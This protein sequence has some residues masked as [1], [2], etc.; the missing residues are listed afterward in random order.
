MRPEPPEAD[1]P[2]PALLREL[3]DELTTLVR[4][5]LALARAE[6]TASAKPVAASAGMLGTGALFGLGAFGAGTA[7][8]IALIGIWLPVW[9]AAL[10]VTAIYGCVAFVA[11]LTAK[12]TLHDAAP[13]GL[14]RTAQTLK[15]DIEWAKTRAKSSA[16]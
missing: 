8:L 14:E 6:I 16:R 10:L 15:E 13:L 3:G 9:G 1:R 4:Q 7:F 12:K 2:L 5:E 11:A